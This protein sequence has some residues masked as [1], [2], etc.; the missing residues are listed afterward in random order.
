MAISA[1][2][3]AGRYLSNCKA[4]DVDSQEG[5]DIKLSVDRESERLIID[6]LSSSGFPILAEES[7]AHGR[8]LDGKTWIID[9]LDGTANYWRG[10]TDLSCVSIALWDSNKPIFGVIYRFATDDLY[11]GIIG[12]GAYKN[13][14]NINTSSKK[15][16]SDAY[17]ATGF[18]VHSNYSETSLKKRVNHFKKFKKIRML[19]SAALMGAFVANGLFDIY[20]EE[21][22][23]MWDIASSAAIVLSAG[24]CM[25][26][27]VHD[28]YTCDCYLFANS[29][30]RDAYHGTLL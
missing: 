20:E 28:D 9:P 17:L 8:V 4:V 16:L 7:G 15:Q 24:G 13:G 5:R 2:K 18:P 22:I 12:Q 11:Y 29:V 6:C 25:D 26:L 10:I 27:E 21:G 23:M 1:A 19:G 3:L 14:I 30:L